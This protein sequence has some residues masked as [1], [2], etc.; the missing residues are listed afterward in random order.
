M[1]NLNRRK[2]IRPDGTVRELTVHANDGIRKL[3]ACGRRKWPKC[4]H[5]YHFNF[6]WIDGDYRFSLE[7]RVERVVRKATKRGRL[8]WVRDLATLG[9]RIQTKTDAAGEAERLRV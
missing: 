2:L 8:T 6:R 4:A 9:D 1:A 7:R 3:C 5:P